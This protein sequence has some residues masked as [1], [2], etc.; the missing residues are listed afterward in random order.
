MRGALATF[1]A[2]GFGEGDVT[3][4][5]H[6]GV[7][8]AVE[9]GE[10]PDVLDI[11]ADLH[12]APAFDALGEVEDDGASGGVGRDVLDVALDGLERDVEVRGERLQLALAVAS[13]GEAGLRV[14]GQDELE[15]GAP[16]LDDLAIVGGDFHAVLEGRAARA[17]ELVAT[18]VA[19]D[20]DAAG[21]GGQ[22][23][24]VL[25]E[26]GDVHLDAPGGVENG[27]ARRNL[28]FDLVDA[29]GD[30]GETSFTGMGLRVAEP[31]S[32]GGLAAVVA[33]EATR[34]ILRA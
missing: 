28:D 1:H 4:G 24:P 8:A 9:Q 7:D 3:G 18:L 25:A 5:R 31:A 27:G 26:R 12:A 22:E 33:T 15:R 19:D 10:G 13:A 29:G 23:V 32:A 34:L 21:S 16:H 2:R 17:D 14:I 30:H 11:L 20:A 6:A